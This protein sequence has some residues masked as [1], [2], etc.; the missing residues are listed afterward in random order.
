MNRNHENIVVVAS[1]MTIQSN[2]LY[3]I[4]M[5]TVLDFFPVGWSNWFRVIKVIC[6]KSKADDVYDA[7]LA[8]SPA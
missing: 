1:M 7:T 5:D 4:I 6:C 8:A 2:A 3:Q